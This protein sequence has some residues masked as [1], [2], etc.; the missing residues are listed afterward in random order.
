MWTQVRRHLFRPLFGHAPPT[1]VRA[2]SKR[3]WKGRLTHGNSAQ[4]H[5]RRP[6]SS[7]QPM[8]G[9]GWCRL[10]A[11]VHGMVVVLAASTIACSSTPESLPIYGTVVVELRVPRGVVPLGGTYLVT[12]DDGDPVRFGTLTPKLEPLRLVL[13]QDPDYVL[14]VNALARKGRRG[15]SLECE[16]FR[17]FDVIR[18]RETTFPLT[19]DCD[20]LWPDTPPPGPPSPDAGCG[21]EALVVGPLRQS[22]GASVHASA[23]A[24]PDGDTRFVW[25]TSD[26]EIGAFTHPETDSVAQTEF[27]CY[28]PGVTTL[29]L[30][31]SSSHCT[32]E[33]TVRVECVASS[34]G[35]AGVP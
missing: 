27:T 29:S 11:A 7:A 8:Q 20:G 10:D 23:T 31:V 18:L 4:L 30:V 21:I 6:G 5:S 25:G 1:V 33:A 19:L 28:Q 3:R 13:P 9:R 12:S 32:D 22:I 14:S 26:T 15:V 2:I 16:G 34:S 17:K 35:D 24:T